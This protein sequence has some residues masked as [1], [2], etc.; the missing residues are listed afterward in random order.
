MPQFRQQSYSPVVSRENIMRGAFFIILAELFFA[1]GDATIKSL[2]AV[3][4]NTE[5]VF[6]RNLFGVLILIP[7]LI[8]NERDIWQTNCLHLH[9]IRS[10]CGITAMYCFFYGL[11]QIPLLSAMLIKSAIPIIIPLFAWIWLKEKINFSVLVA[12]AIGFSGVT[13]ILKPDGQ[14]DLSIPSLITMAGSILAAFSFVT[15][16]KLSISEPALRIVFYFAIIGLCVS[17]LPAIAQWQ[18]PSWQEYLMLATVGLSTTIAQLLLTKGYSAAPAGSVGI[19][20]YISIPFGGILGWLIWRETWDI[21][22]LLGAILIVSAGAI[23]L[24]NK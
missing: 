14:Q 22:S 20:T 23:V 16:R 3:L 13:L 2:A 9:L 1:L 21:A 19:F 12:I 6:F 11:G 8:K 5:I 17:T 24:K 10:L 15:V 4:P 18:T 7:L